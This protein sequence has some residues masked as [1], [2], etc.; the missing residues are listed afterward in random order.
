[1]RQYLLLAS[2]QSVNL[3]DHG[4]NNLQFQLPNL[5]QEPPLRLLPVDDMEDTHDIRRFIVE[6]LFPTRD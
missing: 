6:I 3:S 4:I 2:S 5:S 1:M